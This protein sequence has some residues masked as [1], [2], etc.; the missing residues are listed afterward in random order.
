MKIDRSLMILLCKTLYKCTL[1]ISYSIVALKYC[2]FSEAGVRIIEC[3]N[4]IDK[5]E[6]EET[7]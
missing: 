4:S 7:L 6:L 1:A 3:E 5:L 2:S